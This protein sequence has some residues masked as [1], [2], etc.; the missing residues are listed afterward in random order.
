[1]IE[2][3]DELS[4]AIA[5]MEKVNWKINFNRLALAFVQPTIHNYTQNN[6]ACTGILGYYC[7][8]RDAN[9]H[10]KKSLQLEDGAEDF[11]TLKN[12]IAQFKS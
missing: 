10:V 7:N 12:A 5:A 6:L 4:N 8:N 9:L 11:T 2:T 3:L 1:M